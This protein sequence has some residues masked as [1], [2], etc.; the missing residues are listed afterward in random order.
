MRNPV[1]HECASTRKFALWPHGSE[2]VRWLRCEICW[3]HQMRTSDRTAARALCGHRLLALFFCQLSARM[4]AALVI[5]FINGDVNFFRCILPQSSTLL[6]QCRHNDKS[7][8]SKQVG[9]HCFY[10]SFWCFLLFCLVLFGVLVGVFWG[11]VG[12]SV[13]YLGVF[14]PGW[15]LGNSKEATVISRK[16][17]G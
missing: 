17:H 5:G 2:S 13:I 16:D 11:G 1:P 9:I 14:E 12:L 3:T 8:M 7:Y 6:S 15:E 4:F 10:F